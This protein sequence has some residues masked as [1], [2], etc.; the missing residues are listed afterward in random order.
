MTLTITEDGTPY[1]E[2]Y[3]DV[4]YSRG[5]GLSESRYVFLRANR[6]PQSWRRQPCFVIGETGFGAGLN[7]LATW[8]LWRKTR[9][10]PET[11]H[12]I[13]I[14]KHPLSTSQ[15]ATLHRA[16]DELKL[17]S[18]Q[19]LMQY[20]EATSGFHRL[21]FASHRVCLTLCFM[22]VEKALR[23]LSCQ[24]DCWFLDGF[25][26]SKNPAM[27][28]E[29]NIRL[30]AGL[31]HRGTNLSTFTAAGEVGRRLK[32]YGFEVKKIPG[33][34]NKR[35]MITARLVHPPGRKTKSPWYVYNE[36]SNRRKHA[37][38]IGAG[39]AGSQI[40]WHL[41]QKDWHVTVI[42]RNAKPAQEASGNP[43]AIIAPKIHAKPHTGEEFHL[44][45]YQYVLNQLKQ[46]DPR[47]QIWNPCGVIHLVANDR[48]RQRWQSLLQRKLPEEIVQCLIKEDSSQKA[49][50]EMPADGIFFPGGCWV[51]PAEFCKRLLKHSNIRVIS[52]LEAISLSQEAAQWRVCDHHDKTIETTA[53]LVIA[54]GKDLHFKEI[55]HLPFVPISGQT[56]QAGATPESRRLKT[57]VNHEG[58]ITPSVDDQHLFGATYDLGKTDTALNQESDRENLEKQSRNLPRYTRYLGEVN[59]AH[60]AIRITAPDRYPYI[61]AVVN[62]GIFLTQFSDISHGKHW[63][64]YPLPSYQQG[65]YVSLAYASRG[66]TTAA[67]CAET[68][69]S[70]MAGEPLPV[71]Q[72]IVNA[73]HPSRYLVRSLKKTSSISKTNRG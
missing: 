1:C 15:L 36:G 41:A 54:S 19:L 13:S 11:L 53:N 61:G 67:L 4:Y 33:F 72:T 29:K 63:Q 22:D 30:L 20:P 59:G 44:S 31:S 25:A 12:F 47:R 73:V 71:S 26:P 6:L 62:K 51:K 14:E 45:C 68:L 3:R 27:W 46:L 2:T 21:R 58:Y 40:A 70:L 5:S 17:L 69:A 10:R 16:F 57:I 42:E 43:L 55:D 18:E 65:L 37:A 7:F 34:G 38:V 8:D 60:A 9:K 66:L 39:I 35:E 23:E 48:E 64:S 32:R 52:A 49:G 56:S 28:T 24:M 50:V